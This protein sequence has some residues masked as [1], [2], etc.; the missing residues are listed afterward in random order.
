MKLK[1]FALLAEI[2]SAICI[3]LSL[4]FVGIE[5]QQNTQ[6]TVAQ[7]RQSIS[8][9]YE[10]LA[11][12]QASSPEL[13]IALSKARNGIELSNEEIPL[14]QGWVYAYLRLT[15]EA[16]LQYMEGNLSELYW[17]TRAE[18]LLSVALSTQLARGA[19]GCIGRTNQRSFVPE[20]YEWLCSS[21]NE[22]YRDG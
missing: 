8:S 1:D 2:I 12:T 13:A 7:N 9:R 3:V 15:E 22:R 6:A 18:P 21:L 14:L 17:L 16:Y 5:I 19:A 10:T 11:L 20:F 4:I